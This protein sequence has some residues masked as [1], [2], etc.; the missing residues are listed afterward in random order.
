MLPRY[1]AAGIYTHTYT[2]TYKHI[3]THTHTYTYT[4]TYIYTYT[5]TYTHTHTHT[6]GDSI[7][8]GEAIAIKALMAFGVTSAAITTYLALTSS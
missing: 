1:Y 2:H 7:S 3:Y 6:Q 8:A 4:Y 5:H